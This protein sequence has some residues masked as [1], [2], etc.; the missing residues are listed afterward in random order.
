MTTSELKTRLEAVHTQVASGV[1]DYA[2]ALAVS[3]N[4]M[5]V[6]RITQTGKD[7]KGQSFGNYSDNKLPLFFFEARV[8]N[9]AGFERL[10][11]QRKKD[12]DPKKRSSASYAEFR[13]SQGLENSYKNF[14]FS[15]QM[16]TGI[17]YV[18]TQFGENHLITIAPTTDYAKKVLG[19]VVWRHGKI[20]LTSE[21]E[22]QI[23]QKALTQWVIKIFENN[24]LTG[25]T[26]T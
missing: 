24:G 6:N 17:S 15:G 26:N 3:A 21:E 14:E 16:F 7:H 12:E 22:Q 19:Y 20:L 9:K 1:R 8:L 18:V 23:L 25:Q 5:I 2:F 10:K 13:I 4:T 11:K